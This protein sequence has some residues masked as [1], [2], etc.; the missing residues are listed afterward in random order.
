MLMKLDRKVA[1]EY[2]FLAA[3]P[4]MFA[5]TSYDLYQNWHV[6]SASDLPTFIVGFV[7]SFVAAAAAVKTFIRILQHWTLRPFAIYRI[8]ISPAI[9]LMAG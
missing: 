9:Y 1:A 4:V 3:V 7:V 8:I 5:A 6:L 2:S